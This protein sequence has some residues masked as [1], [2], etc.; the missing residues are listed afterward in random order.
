VFR[1]SG[2]PLVAS[3]LEDASGRVN[4]RIASSDGV[5]RLRRRDRRSGTK[6]LALVSVSG[7]GRPVTTTRHGNSVDGAQT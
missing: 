5:F 4:T 7:C 2:R 1:R 3:A 6:R